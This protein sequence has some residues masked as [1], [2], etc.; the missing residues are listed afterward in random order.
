MPIKDRPSLRGYLSTGI[1]KTEGQVQE[2]ERVQELDRSYERNRKISM[3]AY[4][5][6]HEL[7][8]SKS[9]KYG[10]R[11]IW[12]NP[13]YTSQIGKMKYMRP[14]GLAVHQAAAY[15]IARRGMGLNE[16]IPAYLVKFLPKSH[17]TMAGKYKHTWHWWNYFTREIKRNKIPI[18][19][20]YGDVS[21]LN[22]LSA[23]K[24]S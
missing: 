8:E 10:I 21:K 20:F 6:I 1:V 15:V 19:A 11:V 17:A 4:D 9:R 14:K 16:S 3:F 23:L 7:I 24:A 13:A 18:A 2:Q 5:K 22:S 12:I